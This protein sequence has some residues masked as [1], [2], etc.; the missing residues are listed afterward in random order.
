V[1]TTRREDEGVSIGTEEASDLKKQKG[2]LPAIS[3]PEKR[4][5]AEI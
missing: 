1:I 5:N 2:V 3:F 4:Q